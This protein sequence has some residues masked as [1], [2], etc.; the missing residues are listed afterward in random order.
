M[1][2][3]FRLINGHVLN[4]PDGTSEEDIYKYID[5]AYPR[6][7]AFVASAY[8]NNPEYAEEIPFEDYKALREWESKNPE[9]WK[10]LGHYAGVGGDTISHMAAE[11]GEGLWDVGTGWTRGEGV[12]ALKGAV[13]GVNMGSVDLWFIGMKVLAGSKN[14][15][16]T[17]EKF[18]QK[19]ALDEQRKVERQPDPFSGSRDRSVVAP[20]TEAL[21]VLKPVKASRESYEKLL[22][23]DWNKFRESYKHENKTAR[24]AEGKEGYIFD[25]Y[26]KTSA[27]G[28]RYA[29]PD[30]IATGLYGLAGKGVASAG[31]R[32]AVTQPAAGIVGRGL[33]AVGGATTKAGTAV[34]KTGEAIASGVARATEATGGLVTPGTV[35]AAGA[36]VAG[37]GAVAGAPLIF[38][39]GGV[40][41]AA[42]AAAPALKA[43]GSLISGTGRTVGKAPLPGGSSCATSFRT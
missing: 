24:W 2:I 40:T 37:G 18:L 21:P 19:A 16:D 6:T 27:K 22:R 10:G 36:T 31:L 33:A 23:G 20:R 28:F 14:A 17:Y 42:G 39:A 29:S 41:T 1:P 15:P 4:F 8:V 30:I 7:G 3:P 35:T 9:A 26:S 38:A 5:K 12:H 32:T 13:E 34:E 11:I 43:G 25:D